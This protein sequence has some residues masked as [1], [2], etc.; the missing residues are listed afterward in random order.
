M[1]NVQQMLKH[2]EE[3]NMNQAEKY[4][5]SIKET[6]TDE[7]IFTSAEELHQLGFLLEAK[8]LY[9]QLIQSY[10]DEGELKILL[11]EVYLDLDQ[12]D[13]A[14]F[15]LDTIMETDPDYPRALLLLADL[16]QMQGLIEVSERKLQEAKEILPDEPIIDFALGEL[17]SASGNY[18]DAIKYYRTVLNQG[19]ETIAGNNIHGRLAEVL[20]SAGEFEEALPHYDQALEEHLEINTL[21]GFGFTAYKAGHYRKAIEIFLKLKDIDP[22]FHSLYL[23]LGRA[24]EQEED[25]KQALETVKAGLKVDEFNK[26]L[27]QF[28]GK[29]ALKSGEEALAED[30]FRNALA[31]DP[32]YI[33]AAITLNKLL[34]HQK[35]F[36]DVLEISKQIEKE[37]DPDPS[38][39]WDM[40][41]AYQ[42]IEQY[43]QALKYYE[44]AYN[45]LKN[46][47]EF[48]EEYGYFLIEEGKRDEAAQ[49]FHSLL[50]E[51]PTNE[52]WILL[53]ERFE[54]E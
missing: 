2:I 35:R 31:L 15:Q 13:E 27:Y 14:I 12:E 16:Y 7:E 52:E 46:N 48:L 22:E 9:E 38:I 21:F 29:I 39:Y 6:G 30:Y 17:Y 50:K 44:L 4:L 40:A 34:L 18:V 51:D 42:H 3:G 47:L 20:S 49:I 53:L 45:D 19:H 26:E 37:G 10:P 32:G 5:K 23:Y 8:E 1:S 11:S 24:Y 28:G 43:S 25:V 41:I 54:N 36:E 33:D